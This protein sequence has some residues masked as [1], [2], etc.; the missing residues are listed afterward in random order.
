M[1]CFFIL[2]AALC[3]FLLL[4]FLC[5]T[6]S[7]GPTPPLLVKHAYWGT[8]L[9]HTNAANYLQPNTSFAR[10]ANAAEA[11]RCRVIRKPK[12]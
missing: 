10:A 11:V 6:L 12:A 2:D 7:F 4:L 1:L 5:S 3:V 9:A 8:A